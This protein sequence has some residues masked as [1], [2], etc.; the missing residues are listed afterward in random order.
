MSGKKRL[1]GQHRQRR[2][3]GRLAVN[4]IAPLGASAAPWRGD[5]IGTGTGL[6]V[7]DGARA[8]WL[9]GLP[10]LPARS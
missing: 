10:A 1:V 9:A 4:A 8:S 5:A 2:G 3:A 6:F 7:R